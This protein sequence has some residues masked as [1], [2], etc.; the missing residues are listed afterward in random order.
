MC[1]VQVRPVS[2]AHNVLH[3]ND[4]LLAIDGHEVANDGT[5]NWRNRERIT[6]DYLL[7]QK[8]SG[9]TCHLKLLRNGEEM[10]VD[11]RLWPEQHLT[12]VHQYDVK[13]PQYFIFGGLVFTPLVQ[14]YLHEWG[15]DW[16]NRAPRKLCELA[17]NKTLDF[18][19]QQIVVLSQVL[20]HQV[21]HMSL[22]IPAMGIDPGYEDGDGHRLAM[23]RANCNILDH[24][25]HSLMANMVV[26]ECWVWR[27]GEY[28]S[29]SGRRD[30]GTK[31]AA[32]R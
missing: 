4:I 2:P 3:E 28:E 19:G 17:M 16:Y 31:P 5:I 7:S 22:M 24:R 29:I 15:D 27:Y 1:V 12:P 32:F 26:G 20:S 21:N 13:A 25:L 30:C 23:D 11:V 9:E 6:F 18:E 8:F 10:D 14:P